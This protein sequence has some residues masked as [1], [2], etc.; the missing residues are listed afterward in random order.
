MPSDH[1]QF[2]LLKSFAMVGDSSGRPFPKLTYGN[3]KGLGKEVY[4][5][6]LS[7][8]ELVEGDKNHGALDQLPAQVEGVIIELPADRTAGVIKQVAEMGVKDV[9]IHMGCE[10]P[11]ALAV[12]EESGIRV[13][14][15]TCAV[16]Y[17][18]QGFSYH[19]IHKWLR[20]MSGKY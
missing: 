12:C 3:L 9:W 6:D 4:A 17:T 15:G 1:E 7:G 11:E 16:M 14:T 20:K 8:A 2:F 13:R 5:V 18:Q 10:T 19:S